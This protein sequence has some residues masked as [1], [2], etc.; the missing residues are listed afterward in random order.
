M[1]V[2]IGEKA[3]R[4]RVQLRGGDASG[5]QVVGTCLAVAAHCALL[6]APVGRAAACW[7]HTFTRGLLPPPAGGGDATVGGGPVEAVEAAVEHM[8]MK[9]I[10]RSIAGV[11]RGAETGGA[12][13]LPTWFGVCDQT[14]APTPI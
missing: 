2:V 5:C 10:V 13:L 4:F 12:S 14:A 7:L 11:K 3:A 8:A 6:A 9:S 1:Q